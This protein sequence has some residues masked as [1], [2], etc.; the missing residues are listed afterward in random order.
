MNA[1]TFFLKT[2]HSLEQSFPGTFVPMM[3]LSFSGPFVPWNIRSLDSSFPGTFVP[4]T[5]HPGDFLSRERINTADL[6]LH[7]PFVP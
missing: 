5:V 1:G 6:S 2:I 4:G 7:G 3:D